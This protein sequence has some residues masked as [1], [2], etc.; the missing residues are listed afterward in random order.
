MCYVINTTHNAQF[1]ISERGIQNF[2]ISRHQLRIF[3]ARRVTFNTFGTI[4]LH[5]FGDLFPSLLSGDFCSVNV[6]ITHVRLC[7]NLLKPLGATVKIS[8]TRAT[9]RLE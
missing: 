4:Y 9:R 6:K 3:G 2:K 7:K 5:F 8:D 1:T